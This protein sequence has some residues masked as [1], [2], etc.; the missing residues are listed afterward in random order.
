MSKEGLQHIKLQVSSSQCEHLLAPL[1]GVP[2][3]ILR[4]N[5]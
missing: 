1:S 2:Y 5:I 3:A 4:H